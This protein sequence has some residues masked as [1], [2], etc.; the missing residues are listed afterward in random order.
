MSSLTLHQ[1][2]TNPTGPGSGMVNARYRIIQDLDARLAGMIRD[3]K[4]FRF[5][6]YRDSGRTVF[7]VQVPSETFAEEF[8]FD[9]VIEV[10]T[11]SGL[12]KELLSSPVKVYSNS[13]AFMFTY[14]YVANQEG[15]L[16][17]WLK[18]KVGHTALTQPPTMRNPVETLGFEK[19][20]YYACQY[21]LRNGLYKPEIFPPKGPVNERKIRQIVQDSEGRHAAYVAMEAKVVEAKRKERDRAKKAAAASSRADTANAKASAGTGK[22]VKSARTAKS[23]KT[24]KTVA[25]KKSR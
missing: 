16:I 5:I 8:F 22:A 20:I 18:E 7:H 17:P 25:R 12:K 10:D 11:A 1:L 6:S 23:A 3:G 13:P 2:L 14:A 19:S 15:L 24:A 9:V 21:V 4:K